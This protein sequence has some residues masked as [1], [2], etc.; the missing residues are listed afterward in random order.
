[1]TTLEMAGI[2]QPRKIMQL[3]Q[4][5]WAIQAF[6]TSMQFEIVSRISK[7]PKSADEIFR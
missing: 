3:M 6:H 5:G 7:Q 2:Q 1:M 4:A